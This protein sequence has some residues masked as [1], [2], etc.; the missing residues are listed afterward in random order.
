MAVVL[1]VTAHEDDETLSMGGGIVNHYNAGHKIYTLV[2]TDGGNSGVWS[3]SYSGLTRD[4]FCQARYNEYINATAALGVY[5]QNAANTTCSSAGYMGMFKDSSLNLGASYV[6]N[7]NGM[8]KSCVNPGYDGNNFGPYYSHVNQDLYNV[9]KASISAIAS[10]NGISTQSVRVK[11][12]SHMDAHEDHRAVCQAVLR[13]YDE[14]FI[15]DL[16]HYLSPGQW[17]TSVNYLGKTYP[18]AATLGASIETP[19]S[20]LYRLDDAIKNYVKIGV[21]TSTGIAGADSYGIGYL[22]VPGY[23][24]KVSQRKCSYYHI[25]PVTYV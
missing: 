7:S 1:F 2:C 16:R 20:N 15:T 3:G 18:S 8:T 14:G 22:S 24:D 6:D 9:I 13:L 17:D 12:H 11:T 25:P 10:D 19:S 23:F 4:Q 5:S 21:T